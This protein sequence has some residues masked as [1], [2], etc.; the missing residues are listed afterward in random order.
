MTCGSS[1]VSSGMEGYVTYR[2]RSSTAAN[3]ATKKIRPECK[4]GRG[5]EVSETES[6]PLSALG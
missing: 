2:S 3:P 4:S 6:K 1:P 5:K